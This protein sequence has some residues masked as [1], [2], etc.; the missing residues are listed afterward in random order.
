[1]WR[2]TAWI[3]PFPENFIFPETTAISGERIAEKAEV[4]WNGRKRAEEG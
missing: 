3:T 2:R 4:E 1:L